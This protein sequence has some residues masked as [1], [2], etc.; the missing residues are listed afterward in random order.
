MMSGNRTR[1]RRMSL[2]SQ[3][4]RLRGRYLT[5][6][7]GSHDTNPPIIM[8]SNDSPTIIITTASTSST[9]S[10]LQPQLIHLNSVLDISRRER[11]L[12][13]QTLH[14]VGF[15]GM[16]REALESVCGCVSAGSA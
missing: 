6:S 1:R 13:A 16:D 11:V 14:P 7:N 5:S 9:A 4:A 3:Y 15:S 10:T 2:L 12:E 8:I